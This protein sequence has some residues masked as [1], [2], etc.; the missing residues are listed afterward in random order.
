MRHLAFTFFALLALGMA[1]ACSSSGSGGAASPC[2]VQYN[3]PAKQTCWPDMN[4]NFKCLNSGSS[5]L[6][7]SCQNRAGSPTC[8]DKLACFA[9]T[10]TNGVCAQYC[11]PTDPTMACPNSGTCLTVTLATSG[12]VFHVCQPAQMVSDGGTDSGGQDSGGQDSGGQDSSGDDAAGDTG[13]G[14]AGG[15]AAAD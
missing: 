8:S 14:D 1:L 6:G 15:D 2:N 5:Q 11:D 13:G 7:D 4:G 12:A 9:T 3:C 10:A